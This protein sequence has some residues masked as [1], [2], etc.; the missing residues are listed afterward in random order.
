MIYWPSHY[1]AMVT[2]TI[3]QILAI[4]CFIKKH[5]QTIHIIHFISEKALFG[6]KLGIMNF[7]TFNRICRI[8]EQEF[9]IFNRSMWEEYL[10]KLSINFNIEAVSCHN[11]KHK[12][13][14]STWRRV[15]WTTCKCTIAVLG[16]FFKTGYLRLQHTNKS[17]LLN[18]I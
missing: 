13:V 10:D 9:I 8:C 12:G 4:T 11:V 18:Y 14:G 2:V 1:M 15:S 17:S 3:Q 5:T 16:T 7:C 6:N